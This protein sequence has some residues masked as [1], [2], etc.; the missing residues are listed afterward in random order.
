MLTNG[1]PRADEQRVVKK[2]SAFRPDIQMLRAVAVASV[3]IFHLLPNL[4]PGGFL[5]VD[6]FFVI[7]GYLITGHLLREIDATGG[8][9]WLNFFK[10]RALRLFP[11]A[12][13]VLVAVVILQITIGRGDTN[14]TTFVGALASIFYI[15]NWN[16]AQLATDYFAATS[17]ASPV[18]HY[19]SLSVEEQFYILWPIL[20]ALVIAVSR[21]RWRAIALN[22]SLFLVLLLAT[23]LSFF[24]GLWQTS[25]TPAAYFDTFARLWEFGVGALLSFLKVDRETSNDTSRLRPAAKILASWVGFVLIFG[26]LFI[27]SDETPMPGF[28]ALIPVAGTALVLWAG[29][30]DEWPA[31]TAISRFAPIQRLGNISYSVYLWHWPLIVFYPSVFGAAP[32][33]FGLAGILLVTVALAV[34]SKKFIEDPVRFGSISVQSPKTVLIGLLLISIISSASIQVVRQTL[35]Q[36]SKIDASVIVQPTDGIQASFETLA[37]YVSTC[38]AAH[39]VWVSELPQDCA[40]WKPTMDTVVPSLND[41]TKD[42]VILPCWIDK[43]QEFDHCRL[44]NQASQVRIALYGDSHAAMM[45]PG[46]AEA[47][48]SMGVALDVFTGYDCRAEYKVP[49]TCSTKQEMLEFL[50]NGE[51][52]LILLVNSRAFTDSA[53]NAST[54]SYKRFVT[55]LQTP[56]TVIGSIED[57]PLISDDA[58][59]CLNNSR[60]DADAS[61]TCAVARE[62]A[63]TKHPDLLAQAV[64]DLGG[65]VLRLPDLLCDQAKCP[66][67]IGN[68]IVY[69]ESFGSH[70]TL[71]FSKSLNGYFASFLDRVIPG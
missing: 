41:L 61:A 51:Y 25:Q 5:G 47:A 10:R 14:E 15:Q 19:W 7:S 40:L 32:N 63:L 60:G 65:P 31:P 37:E 20:M 34:V 24:F 68:A 66:V 44:G 43:D 69:I 21:S 6:I 53:P 71:T 13:T 57:V 30:I 39:T 22:R 56:G 18:Q 17:A 36:S 45:V 46:L 1:H 33:K 12:L 59:L 54:A 48:D 49:T 55:Q 16:L 35:G 42:A 3:L 64:S 62:E 9:R 67:V 23:V 50:K 27:Y 2:R 8:V 29:Q 38:L 52:D 11:A 28:A 70:I 26:P 4:I 58:M